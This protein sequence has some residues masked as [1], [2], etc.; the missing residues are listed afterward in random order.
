MTVW[1]PDTEPVTIDGYVEMPGHGLS[2]EQLGRGVTQVEMAYGGGVT[3]LVGEGSV[4]TPGSLAALE[5]AR[6]RFGNLPL[7]ASLAPSIRAARSGFPL[8]SACHRYLEYSGLSIFGHNETSRLALHPDGETLLPVGGLVHLPGLADTLQAIADEGIELFY[9]GELAERIVSHVRAGGGA[10]TMEDMRRYR[11]IERGAVTIDVGQWQVALNPPPSIGGAVLGALLIG[12]NDGLPFLPLLRAAL[13]HRRAQLDLAD[14]LPA[15]GRALLDLARDGGLLDGALQSGST[16]HTS[17]VDD[18]GL[19]CAITASAGYG[20]GEIPD[21]TGLWLNNCL[22]EIELN[23]RGLVAG[24]PGTRL[25]SNMAPTAARSARRVLAIGSPGAGR[26][27][28]ALAQTLG[29]HLLGGLPLDDAI[30]SPRL[31]VE[32]GVEC[33]PATGRFPEVLC[34]EPGAAPAGGVS[35]MVTRPFDEPSMYFGGVGA[36]ACDGAGTPGASF[37]VAAD[38]RRTGAICIA[39]SRKR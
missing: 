36:A 31:H 12:L 6:A 1:A 15:A 7:S 28:S 34:F 13:Q 8:P 38:P 16:V 39:K 22:G 20:S 11:A 24:P 26:I 14:D 18:N 32:T 33:D 27:T 10:L 23:R 2:P 9:R 4:A 29:H 25:P 19:A 37:D 3:T 35:G 30:A 5:A 17:A 21:G